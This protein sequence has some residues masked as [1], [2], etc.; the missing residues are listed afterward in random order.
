VSL[1][2]EIQQALLPSP[3][4]QGGSYAVAAA[5]LPCRAIGGDFFDYFELPNGA[6]AFALGDVAGKGPSAALLA[7]VIQGIFASH[8][9]SGKGPAATLRHA[10][11]VLMRRTIESRFPTAVYGVFVDGQLT[12]CNSPFL[13]GRAGQ[14]RL[15]K[16][17]TI[18]GIFKETPFEEETVQLQPGDT[19]VAFTDR[20]REAVNRQ[21]EEFGEERLTRCVQ[22]SQERAPDM[23]LKNLFDAVRQFSDGIPQS[24][25]ITALVFRYSGLQGR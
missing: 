3:K 24:D 25:D 14:R 5:S 20:V 2:A 11:K 13:V 1:A 9:Q 6:F 19:L 4:Y 22:P 15:D 17:G 18:L 21:G 8:A 23:L 16:G 12:Y 7:G 10:N